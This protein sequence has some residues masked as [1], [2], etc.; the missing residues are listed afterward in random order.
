[1]A[2]YHIPKNTM[3]IPLLCAINTDPSLWTD[4]LT[5]RPERFLDRSSDPVS[6]CKPDYFMPFQTGDCC[7]DDEHRDHLRR[8][9]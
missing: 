5:F 7:H 8:E 9:N 3:V 2:G 4:P 6:V 1:L